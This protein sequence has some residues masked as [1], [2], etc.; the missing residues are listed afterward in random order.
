MTRKGRIL[1][2]GDI[3]KFYSGDKYFYALIIERKL[4]KNFEEMAD[5]VEKSELG[6]KNKSKKEM[7]E[8]YRS[9]YTLED[10]LRF[11]VVIFKVFVL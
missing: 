9:F 10:E 1:T 11:G 7:I 6:F 8:T 2:K 4:F 5:S 3:I